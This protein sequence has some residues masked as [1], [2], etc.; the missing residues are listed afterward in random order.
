MIVK[1]INLAYKYCLHC[2][3]TNDYEFIDS[4]E[5]RYE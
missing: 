2:F 5:L 1:Y 3:R 4:D